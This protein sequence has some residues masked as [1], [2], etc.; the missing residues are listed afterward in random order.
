VTTELYIQELERVR[1]RYVLCAASADL[2]LLKKFIF[3]KFD[4][5][6]QRHAVSAIS[7]L[8]LGVYTSEPVVP[9]GRIA[10]NA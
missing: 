5:S 6:Q 8:S 2:S 7:Y 4:L 1:C 3:L 9:S 10:C